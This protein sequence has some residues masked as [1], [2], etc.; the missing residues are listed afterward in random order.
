MHPMC[1]LLIT[2][3]LT[4]NM[5]NTALIDGSLNPHQL[6][7]TLYNYYCVTLRHVYETLIQ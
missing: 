6:Y 7:T 4:M 2:V 5:P 3:F 1:V